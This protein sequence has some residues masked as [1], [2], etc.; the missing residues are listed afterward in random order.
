MM[1]LMLFHFIELV[2]WNTFL[3]LPLK[4][5]AQSTEESKITKKNRTTDF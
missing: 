2:S 5:L 1:Q 3:L 4:M